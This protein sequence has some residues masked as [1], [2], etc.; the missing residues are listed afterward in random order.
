MQSSS[1][2]CHNT[3]R[4]T[5]EEMQLG[6]SPVHM[7]SIWIHFN[8][9]FIPNHNLSSYV[10]VKSVSVKSIMSK[11]IIVS[12]MQCTREIITFRIS[13]N[14]FACWAEDAVNNVGNTFILILR[15]LNTAN[16]K[17]V[18][19]S[20]FQYMQMCFNISDSS[21]Y[22]WCTLTKYNTAVVEIIIIR[23]RLYIYQQ[24]YF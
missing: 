8:T 10:T 20:I 22:T 4:R 12:D 3:Y 19:H 1:T 5:M 18:V 6:L 23:L 21:I 9:I 16:S 7:I 24:Q 13:M 14:H 15:R 2:I 11:S 17:C